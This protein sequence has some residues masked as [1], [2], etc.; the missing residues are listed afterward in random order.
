V[1]GHIGSYSEPFLPQNAQRFAHG[2]ISIRV[3]TRNYKVIQIDAHRHITDA[4][5]PQ[6][7][8]SFDQH[9]TIGLGSRRCLSIVPAYLIDH[10]ACGM[11]SPLSPSAEG[12]GHPWW[13]E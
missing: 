13:Q 12:G 7:G 11:R 9:Y 1:H 8:S 2:G 5:L 6:P 3:D 10:P 4:I